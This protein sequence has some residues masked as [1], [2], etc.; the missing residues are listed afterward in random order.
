M[1]LLRMI[2]RQYR[3]S[4]L[5]R[6]ILPAVTAVFLGYFGYH[7]VNGEY[8]MVGRARFESRTQELNAELA[9]LNAEKAALE[10]H[11]RLLRPSSLDQDM[12]DE[13]ARVQ[14]SVV[15]PNEVVIMDFDKLAQ[16]KSN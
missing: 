1:G 10:A 8:G 9:R 15:N 5:R 11:V 4:W 6:L 16:A 7:A 2:T 14:L 13:R 12:V 3:P